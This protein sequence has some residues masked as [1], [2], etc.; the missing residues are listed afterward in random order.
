MKTTVKSYICTLYLGMFEMVNS[1]NGNF[2]Y[3]SDYD[4]LL[5]QN[6]L[7]SI[8]NEKLSKAGDEM[9]DVITKYRCTTRHGNALDS[10]G[11]FSSWIKW[12][13]ARCDKDEIDEIVKKI[14]N[15]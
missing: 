6:E 3:K 13:H 4:D 15:E 11:G 1:E 2:V 14:E 7:L 10:I 12:K 8:K 5:K 9:A